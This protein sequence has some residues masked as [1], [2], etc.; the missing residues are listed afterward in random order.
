M[1]VKFA[2]DPQALLKEANPYLI[3][4]DRLIEKW[5][6]FG[7]LVNA[8]EI[9]DKID[10]IDADIREELEVILKDDETP[11][12]Y[13]FLED[14]VPHVNW[15]TLDDDNIVRLSDFSD[16]FEL[17][18]LNDELAYFIGALE[19]PLSFEQQREMCGGVEPIGLAIADRARAWTRVS[20]LS[21]DGIEAHELH[22]S[23]WN[24]RFSRLTEFAKQI[25][26]IDGNALRNE[27][28]SGLARILN[29]VDR[30]GKDCHIKLFA[31]PTEENDSTVTGLRERLQLIVDRM[32]GG[33]V[34][35]LTVHLLPAS[36]DEARHLL[37]DRYLRFDFNAYQIGNSIALLFMR[38][39]GTVGQPVGFSP[40]SFDYVEERE[41][42]L[43]E[44]ADNLNWLIS[45]C[46]SFDVR[47]TP[48][49]GVESPNP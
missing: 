29:F 9:D 17:A 19:R 1:L 4:F 40:A 46:A 33:G 28:F 6:N 39:A 41:I 14:T 20:D 34:Q 47:P 49:H 31:H 32:T 2:I 27:Q 43:V 45:E 8:S 5:E 25:V 30:D 10:C 38:D 42:Q 22:E 23:L 7:I 11:L 44:K 15:E 13:R 24:G 18:V 35:L 16:S 36:D 3:Y 12:R 26:I 37:H 21:M 48:N